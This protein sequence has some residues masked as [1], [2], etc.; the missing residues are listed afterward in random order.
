MPPAI[1]T[2]S[3]LSWGGDVDG[4]RGLFLAHLARTFADIARLQ[5]AADAERNPRIAGMLRGMAEGAH[6]RARALT[7]LLGLDPAR[8]H[9][10]AD[11]ERARAQERQA[12]A[13]VAELLAYGP[14]L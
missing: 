14:D 10:R 6:R 1:G 2:R 4:L 12:R 3:R 7:R 5:A 8:R 11:V 9:R 13:I